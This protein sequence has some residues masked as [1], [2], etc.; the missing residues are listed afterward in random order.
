MCGRGATPSPRPDP[1]RVPFMRTPVPAEPAPRPARAPAAPPVRAGAPDPRALLRTPR[2][3]APLRPADVLALQRTVGNRALG[4]L[5]GA[6]TA[7]E[8]GRIQRKLGLELEFAV[9]IDRAGELDAEDHKVLRGEKSDPVRLK[10]IQDSADVPY[11]E[12][13]GIDKLALAA[14]H[15]SRVLP[16]SRTFPHRVL[17]RSILELVF[18]PA[19]ETPEELEETLKAV[20]SA[21][22]QID[23]CTAGLTK[24]IPF[25][26]GL[27][28][29][30]VDGLSKPAE[31]SW[32]A[33]V[34]VNVGI[35]PRRLHGLLKWYGASGYAPASEHRNVPMK[36]ALDITEDVVKVFRDA[37]GADLAEVQ[38]WNGLRGLTLTY[39]MYLLSGGDSSELR[40]TVKNFATILTKTRFV[41]LVAHGMTPKE[42]E[43]LQ[44]MWAEYRKVLVGMTR[45]GEDETQ[46]LIKR[47]K[48]GRP[49]ELKDGSWKI[50]DLFKPGP[51]VLISSEK[52]IR[53]DPVGPERSAADRV[54]GG[55]RRK[56]MVLEFRSLPGSYAA[57]G[58][59]KAARDFMAKADEENS[60]R[61]YTE[62][63]PVLQP[64]SS[65]QEGKT[66]VEQV[67]ALDLP[68][69]P[70]VHPTSLESV[71]SSRESLSSSSRSG[72][73]RRML[74]PLPLPRSQ[75]SGTGSRIGIGNS[76]GGVSSSVVQQEAPTIKVEQKDSFWTVGATVTWKGAQYR[77]VGKKGLW[78]Y[79][80]TPL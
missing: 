63:P 35:D 66:R 54:T 18:K 13:R 9:P 55:G 14:D 67:R 79:E 71:S 52:E 28:I 65:G 29:G 36:T 60:V 45:L 20:D 6:T 39:V 40:S 16:A 41:D 80:L 37:S 64:P 69:I 47:T 74:P 38:H 51:A 76:T 32:N 70:T 11:G 43:W 73:E 26:N 57:E 75:E 42:R 15:S 62:P 17:S 24:R 3:P 30:P 33:S 77:V 72:G 44:G 34:H 50:G 27:H 56:G 61:D 12:F 48:V 68:S 49:G 31:L 4:R 8:R 19:V 78:N 25:G 59:K 23:G 21:I 5:L 46:P 53:A 2:A 1:F 10:A 22:T 7:A 58:W